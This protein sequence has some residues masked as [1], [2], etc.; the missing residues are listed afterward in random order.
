MRFA[1]NAKKFYR[2]TCERQPQWL[3]DFQKV[4]QKGCLFAAKRLSDESFR[5]ACPCMDGSRSPHLPLGAV[6]IQ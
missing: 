6:P 5:S 1:A 4:T 3:G 2:H